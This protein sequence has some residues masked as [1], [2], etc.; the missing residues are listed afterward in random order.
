MEKIKAKVK[1]LIFELS[2]F[3]IDIYLENGEH[4]FFWHNDKHIISLIYQDRLTNQIDEFTEI[5]YYLS[6]GGASFKDY[7]GHQKVEDFMIE[8]ILVELAGDN[9]DI[10]LQ[11]I[12]VDNYEEIPP[13]LNDFLFKT[14]KYI[15][16]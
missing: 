11:R 8:E 13:I 16:A 4:G 3:N 9:R 10:D 2:E 7:E 15:H 6:K 1:A 5:D 12:K 14:Q